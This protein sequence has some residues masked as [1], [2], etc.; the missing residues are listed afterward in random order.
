MKSMFKKALTF[1]LAATMSAAMIPGIAMDIRSESMMSVTAEAANVQQVLCYSN[2]AALKKASLSSLPDREKI[3]EKITNATKNDGSTYNSYGIIV[4]KFQ[5][6]E[7]FVLLYNKSRYD[8]P[9][10]ANVG[11]LID[12]IYNKNLTGGTWAEGYSKYLT[13]LRDLTGISREYLVLKTDTSGDASSAGTYLNFPTAYINDIATAAYITTDSTTGWKSTWA[14]MH[15]SSHAYG[16]CGT[17]PYDYHS[18]ISVNTRL[19]CA[20][21]LLDNLDSR[22]NIM[23]QRDNDRT[24]TSVYDS[25]KTYKTVTPHQ[26]V[27][28][29]SASHYNTF[30]N[31]TGASDYHSTATTFSGKVYGQNFWHQS[32]LYS[33]LLPTKLWSVNYTMAAAVEYNW[34]SVNRAANNKDWNQLYAMQMVYPNKVTSS[35][36]AAAKEIRTAMDNKRKNDVTIVYYNSNGTKTNKTVK[37]SDYVKN[38]IQQFYDSSSKKYNVTFALIMYYNSL[39]LLTNSGADTA[40]VNKINTI[41]NLSNLRKNLTIGQSIEAALNPPAVHG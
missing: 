36:L 23:F 29:S 32:I 26:Y 24:I 28:Y 34:D 1:V 19:L 17:N 8:K 39:D 37:V 35:K 11:K 14:L 5:N 9:N 4:S 25:N 15:E 30:I 3:V 16:E 18:E 21:H 13:A 27:A 20:M 12:H 6:A 2:L 40:R 7:N 22:S 31:S 41:N 38:K 33:Y 10:D